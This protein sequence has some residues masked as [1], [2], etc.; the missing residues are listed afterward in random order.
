MGASTH[1]P[2][3]APHPVP[4]CRGWLRREECRRRGTR[5]GHS[6]VIS[7]PAALQQFC[8]AVG[9]NRPSGMTRAVLITACQGEHKHVACGDIWGPGGESAAEFALPQE[10][11]AGRCRTG[12]WLGME[13]TQAVILAMPAQQEPPSTNSISFSQTSEESRAQPQHRLQPHGDPGDT[14]QSQAMRCS[15]SEPAL[16]LLDASPRNSTGFPAP[17]HLSGAPTS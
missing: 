8:G 5:E 13:L 1:P 3:P 16:T 17:R 15:S 6:S 11:R 9:R 2:R 4:L 10:Q 12:S 7:S 14:R